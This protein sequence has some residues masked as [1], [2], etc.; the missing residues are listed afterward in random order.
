MATDEDEA[1]FRHTL[2]GVLF[3]LVAGM[4]RVFCLVC[5]VALLL[6]ACST[7]EP[8]TTEPEQTVTYTQGIYE[9]TFKAKR[10]SNDSVGNDW[11]ITYKHNEQT[12]NSGHRVLL[13]L[14]VFIFQ[15]VEVEIREHDKLDDV[16]TGDM[17]VAIC[18]GG[19][20]K[21]TITVTENGGRYKGETAVWEITCTV[22]LVGKK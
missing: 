8:E 9:L 11:T 12:V 17:K 15:T 1:L 22:K 20:G 14:E 5:I 16:G 2:T 3:L 21:T 10:V 19:S 4:K 7:P 6:S 13:S 18:D